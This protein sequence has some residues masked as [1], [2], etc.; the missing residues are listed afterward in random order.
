MTPAEAVPESEAPSDAPSPASRPGPQRAADLLLRMFA[1]GMVAFTLLFLVNVYWTFW[2]D[3]PGAFTLF[4]HLGW[5]GLEPPGTPLEGRALAL[6]WLQVLSYAGALGA[7][8]VWVFLS[9]GRAL[10]QDARLWSALAG[11]LVRGAF[12]AVF[13]VGIADAVISLLR[14]EGILTPVVGEALATELGRSIYRG[15]HVHYPLILAAFLIA[16]FS[17][18]LGFTWLALLVVV[19][20][21]QIVIT[22][23]VFSYEQ[24]YMGDL[25]RFWYAALFLFASAHTLVEDGHVRV[26]VFYAGFTE[27]RKA[28]TDALGSALLGMPLCWVILTTGMWGRGSSLINPLINYEISQSAYGMYVK[29]LMAVFLVVFAVTMIVQFAS[30]FLNS[31]AVLRGEP[32]P[33]SESESAAR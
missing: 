33:A 1:G 6:G 17:R 27:R 25:V 18:G 32:E 3:W 13:L 30:Y 19:A 16:L 14:V 26:D 5:F 8:A 2:R 12:W 15:T 4:S 28:W 7:V 29:Y 21:F 9:R 20:E 22:R 11:Y 31:A 24:A 10:R 23:F